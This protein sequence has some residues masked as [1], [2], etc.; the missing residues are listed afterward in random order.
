MRKIK[1]LI[2]LTAWLVF[3]LVGKGT[4]AQEGSD[5]PVEIQLAVEQSTLEVGELNQAILTLRNRTPYTLTHVSSQL[6]GTT[7]SVT[8]SIEL[9]EILAPYSSR[10]ASYTFKSQTA[11]SYNAIFAVQYSWHDPNVGAKQHFIETVVF[12]GIDVTEYAFDWPDY[13]IPLV[14]GLL[15]SQLVTWLN[16]W[17]QE[18]QD[19]QQQEEQAKGIT[20]ALLQAALKAIEAE[21]PVSFDL[22]QDA[23]V[24]GHLYPALHQFGR[25]IGQPELSKG[26]AELSITLEQYNQRQAKENLTANLVSRLKNELTE[27]I[28]A[29]E[30]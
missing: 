7:F 9:P 19:A 20:L 18:R 6:Q 29:L 16:E 21:K 2:C 28:K 26:L 10:Q 27:L 11:G 15:S 23:I 17:R 30:N 5:I 22:W 12:E 14:I 8:H 3:F 13:L 1:W 24:K 4:L 25:K